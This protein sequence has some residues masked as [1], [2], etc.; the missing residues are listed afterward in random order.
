MTGGIG[1]NRA[2]LLSLT[3]FSR[4]RS[5]MD[6]VLANLGVGTLGNGRNRHSVA[7]EEQGSRFNNPVARASLHLPCGSPDV[8]QTLNDL[9]C[10]RF[11]HGDLP[12]QSV[13]QLAQRAH[14]GG[15]AIK[16]ERC[17]ATSDAGARRRAHRIQKT[18][19][20]SLERKEI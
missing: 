3:Y 12:L 19:M 1:P 14:R 4:V 15:L 11:S 20:Y 8:C 10:L 17:I 13:W 5:Q 18:G 9:T 16:P 2:P 6:G 7:V